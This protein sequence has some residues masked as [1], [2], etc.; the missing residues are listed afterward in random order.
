MLDGEERA[1]EADVDRPLEL[2]E[3]V[4]R[5]PAVRPDAGVGDGDVEPAVALDGGRHQALEVGL[6]RDV[7]LL[8]AEVAAEVGPRPVE[9]VLV[10]VADHDRGAL[11][12]E[13]PSAR[14]PD[15]GGAAGHDRDLAL[16]P[17][18]AHRTEA[19]W[20]VEVG[21]VSPWGRASP[22]ACGALARIGQWDIR[23]RN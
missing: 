8:G 5:Q 11:G 18:A 10:T 12:Q 23:I 22:G 2:L 4:V 1:D 6:D 14:Q 3:R 21:T 7:A 20:S 17:S 9:R 13:A 16:Q 19:W 15:A